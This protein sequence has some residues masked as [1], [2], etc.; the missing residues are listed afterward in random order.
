LSQL[1]GH[2]TTLANIGQRSVPLPSCEVVSFIIV[3]ETKY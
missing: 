2:N 1:A 3:S